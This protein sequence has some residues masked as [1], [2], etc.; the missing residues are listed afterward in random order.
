MKKIIVPAI[1]LTLSLSLLSMNACGK[2]SKSGP[3]DTAAPTADAAA[4]D[5][6]GLVHLETTFEADITPVGDVQTK[7]E[8]AGTTEAAGSTTEAKED[9]SGRVHVDSF[10]V[11]EF[12]TATAAPHKIVIHSP[13]V[14]FDVGN[15]TI[16]PYGDVDVNS[17]PQSKL[18]QAAKTQESLLAK[19]T[20]AFQAE[21]I[22]ATVNE[23]SGE[24]S[25][26]SAVLFG[27]DSA[28][29]SSDG[30]AFLNKFIKAYSS[31]MTDPEFSGFVAGIMVEGHTAPVPGDTYEDDL[32]LSEQ[33]AEAVRNYCLSDDAGLSAESVRVMSSL[34]AA[35]GLSNSYPVKD[36]NGNVDMAASRRVAFRFLVNLG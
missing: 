2:N 14:S 25:L 33:R 7:P 13:E 35:Q 31:V 18:E 22:Q 19:L 3:A 36:S 17:I 4:S 1:L 9:S 12:T 30:K 32:P 34:L 27:G 6:S 21:G 28:A 11:P 20:A 23:S 29:L 8:E 16:Y 5:S 15:F 10:S 26:D 24:V